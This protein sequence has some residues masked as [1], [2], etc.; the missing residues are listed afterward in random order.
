MSAMNIGEPYKVSNSEIQTFKL[1]T[2]V[3]SGI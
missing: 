2:V 1:R 3:V